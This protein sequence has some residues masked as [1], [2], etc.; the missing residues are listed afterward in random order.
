MVYLKKFAV[1]G[2]FVFLGESLH[3]YFLPIT[4]RYESVLLTLFSELSFLL[5]IRKDNQ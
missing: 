4:D 3:I 1:G 2:S 5:A